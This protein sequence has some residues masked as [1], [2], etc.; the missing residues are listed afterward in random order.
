MTDN[1]TPDTAPEAAALADTSPTADTTPV[2]EAVPTADVAPS[3]ES[4]QTTDVVA[5]TEAETVPVAAAPA[6]ETAPAAETADTSL[7]ETAP[8][9]ETTDTPLGE[10]TPAGTAE[11]NAE[12]PQVP[13]VAIP[14]EELGESAPILGIGTTYEPAE[15]T[16]TV[17][18]AGADA[19][20][21][22]ALVETVGGGTT[23][24]TIVERTPD[25]TELDASASASPAE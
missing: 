18:Q 12:E 25:Q 14:V 2:G 22:R 15:V 3:V 13:A 8:A 5:V 17:V 23:L 20:A 9:A 21:L 11:T 24:T 1:T 16:R 7:G 10:A 19:P 6:D 4:A